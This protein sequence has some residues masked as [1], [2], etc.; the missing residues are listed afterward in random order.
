MKKLKKML[1]YLLVMFLTFYVLPL[2]ARDTGSAMLILL[3]IMPMIDLACSLRYGQS[4]GFCWLY[5]L[6][7]TILFVPTVFLYY[8]LSAWVYIIGYGF[9][10]LTGNYSGYM[11]LKRKEKNQFF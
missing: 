8:N 6:I 11:L 7:V 10:A 4:E 9:L 3:M 2:F 1:P 5:T